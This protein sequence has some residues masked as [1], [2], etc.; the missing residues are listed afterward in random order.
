MAIVV[1]KISILQVQAAVSSMKS[2]KS[3]FV[4]IQLESWTYLL[5]A[6]LQWI[7]HAF[8]LILFVCVV[9]HINV[10]LVWEVL[11][12]TVSLKNW[13]FSVKFFLVWNGL[14]WI[15][16]LV[17]SEAPLVVG[18]LNHFTP[19]YSF[20]GTRPK[21]CARKASRTISISFH[22]LIGNPLPSLSQ[23]KKNLTLFAKH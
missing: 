1:V 18:S 16:T 11:E 15:S 19:K 9:V 14:G 13:L 12:G 5:A 17:G 10:H 3:L 6:S 22:H 7:V 23:D 2:A 21:R 4:Q 20:C 8:S